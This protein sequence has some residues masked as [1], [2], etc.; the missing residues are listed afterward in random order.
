MDV[1]EVVDN[2]FGYQDNLRSRELS[3][4]FQ[5]SYER[6]VRDIEVS[7]ERMRIAILDGDTTV[8]KYLYDQGMRLDIIDN[9][10]FI[11][12]VVNT[13][14][15]KIVNLLV[16]VIRP[17]YRRSLMKSSHIVIK[18]ME[19]IVG[20]IDVEKPVFNVAD[21]ET[22]FKGLYSDPIHVVSTMEKI[23]FMFN[24]LFSLSIS[25]QYLMMWEYLIPD[26]SPD[27]IR[28]LAGRVYQKVTRSFRRAIES[29]R[30][31]MDVLVPDIIDYLNMEELDIML[32]EFK[33]REQEYS[34]RM[35]RIELDEEEIGEI[36][37]PIGFGVELISLFE[38]LMIAKEGL[39]G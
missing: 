5:R 34:Q 39:N 8:V 14:D 21:I 2:I 3:R 11:T 20:N 35:A 18:N 1:Q 30:F 28:K 27:Q 33:K 23:H 13:D 38:D 15:R 17:Q 24:V 10:E 32:E 9:E 22:L 29:V 31:V 12:T 7:E 36:G 25:P 26:R 37:E 6:L 19:R 4:S 16:K